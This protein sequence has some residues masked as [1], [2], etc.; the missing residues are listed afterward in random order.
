MTA[1][2]DAARRDAFAER[3]LGILNGGALSLMISIGH[4]SG[5][6]DV[7]GRETF[8]TSDALA[9]SSGLQERYVREWLGAM[10]AGGI[11]EYQPAGRSYRLPP[12]HAA[13]LTRDARPNNLAATAQWVPLL[14][15]VEDDVLTCFQ[16]GGGVPYEAFDRFQEVMA[17]ESDQTVVATLCET[18][19]PIV[20]GL[21][22]RLA[23]G[24]DAVDVGCGSGRALNRMAH[25]YPKSRFVGYDVS[26]R[27]VAA[28]R[29]EAEDRALKNVR[30][31][32]RDAV[33]LG[34][35]RSFDLVT[36]FD[37]IHDQAEPVAVLDAIARAL[38]P[39]GVFLMQ[40]IRGTSR[41]ED[42]ARHPLGAFL[43]TV[44][45]LHCM[46]VS[47]A[48]RGAGL[49]A[50]WGVETARR[51]LLEAGF[52]DLEVEALPHDVMNLYYVARKR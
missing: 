2:L 35:A 17:E 10:V 12:E 15:S 48:A 41:V 24:I 9:D 31:E 3:L 1:T 7:M 11:V 39:G 20:P 50:M 25:E 26:A 13:L 34:P 27:A 40:D 43:Y 33:K 4:R 30:F 46:T 49:G 18:I 52:A 28:A 37:A 42:D 45:C 29:A 32:V 6:F 47:L 51:M 16:R 5:L 23:T 44:S 19:L 38:R 21:V 14:A 22:E 8:A 36:A